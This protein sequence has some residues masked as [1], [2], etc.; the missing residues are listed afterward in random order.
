MTTATQNRADEGTV[1]LAWK[2][3]L[4]LTEE[5]VD[6]LDQIAIEYEA[7]LG[8]TRLEALTEIDRHVRAAV[9]QKLQHRAEDV[10]NFGHDPNR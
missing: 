8:T 9:R 3:Q 6:F 2:E 4:L 5:Q 1:T 7:K 10:I